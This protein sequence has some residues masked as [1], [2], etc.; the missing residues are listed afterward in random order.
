MHRSILRIAAALVLIPTPS[1]GQGPPGTNLVVHVRVV[2]ISIARDVSRIAYILR[3]DPRSLERL[4]TFMV[5]VPGAYSE[6]KSI[7][8]PSPRGS[9]MTHDKFVDQAVVGWSA[10]GR[11]MKPGEESPELSFEAVGLPAIVPSS[12]E[13]Y[14]P[15]PELSD[16][17][18]EPDTASAA[19]L[20]RVKG[21]AVGVEYD[22]VFQ[23]PELLLIRLRRLTAQTCSAQLQ[24]VTEAR[25]CSTLD[26][27]LGSASER[28]RKADNPGAKSQLRAFLTQLEAAHGPSGT[29]NDN[30]YWLLKANAGFILKKLL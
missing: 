16:E 30:A 5:E 23:A 9:W 21:S 3:N 28:L 13:G 25:V 29:V 26:T 4:S 11:K 14:T 1:A 27:T 17:P 24:W 19:E 2:S 8:L 6:V 12:I 22:P 18:E 15:V 7:S 20:P 10:L